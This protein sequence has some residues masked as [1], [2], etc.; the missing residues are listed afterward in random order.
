MR[1]RNQIGIPAAII[2]VTID[3]SEEV[4]ELDY[5]PRRSHASMLFSGRVVPPSR[6]LTG[7]ADACFG[8]G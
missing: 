8:K 1:K 6:N 5:P 3:F 4:G 7:R 2:E